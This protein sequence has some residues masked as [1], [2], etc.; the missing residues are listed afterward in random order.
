MGFKKG[1]HEQD[2]STPKEISLHICPDCD[3]KLVQ[4]TSWEQTSAR[5]K[6][7][8]WRR[9][10]EC[11]WTDESVQDQRA[12]DDYDEALEIGEEALK[13]ALKQLEAENMETMAG[14]FATALDQDLIGP[15]DFR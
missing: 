14:S 5:Y 13:E 8:L 4:P 9:C 11:E 7:R 12:I 3:S 15:D 10:P 6:W 1:S 2:P